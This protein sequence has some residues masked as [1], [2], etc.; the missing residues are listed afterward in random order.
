MLC[1]L[2]A[3]AGGISIDWLFGDPPNKYH[4][5]AWMG[6]LI[7][8]FV[9]RLKEGEEKNNGTIFAISLIVTLALTVHVLVF[10]T[11]YLAGVV[12]M[13]VVSA[14]ILKIT[15]AMNGIE[16]HAKAI[17]NC[18]NTGDLPGARQNLSLIVRRKTDD[19]D[20]QHIFSATIECISESTVD[21]ITGPIFYYSFFGPAG[22]FAYRVIN[23]L[24][25][26]IGYKD[27]YFKDIGWMSARL[28]SAANYIPA[29]ITALLMI[30]SAKILGRDW[31]NSF[32]IL[33][34]DHNKTV[35]LN[36]GY[37]MATMAGALR[38]R[39]EK[40]GHYSLGDEQEPVTL[41]KCKEAIWIMKATTL[42]FCF[43]VSVPIIVVLYLAGWWRLV[44]G[45]P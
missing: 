36:A 37:P 4:P 32:S 16:R 26:M 17:M 10:L 14:I 40:I 9:P 45:I 42:L 15:I 39:L 13:A 24:D 6:Q 25:S 5:V 33:K 12:E 35:S 8:F 18:L 23:T 1:L 2:G 22:A 30:V 11:G 31:K 3:L 44:L 27:T 34:R 43:I 29:R 41:E 28:D 7:M 21:G 20:I 19:L 38:I